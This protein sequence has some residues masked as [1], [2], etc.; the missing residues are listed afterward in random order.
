VVSGFVAALAGLLADDDRASDILGAIKDPASLDRIEEA[1]EGRSVLLE[2]RRVT[3][4]R[5]PEAPVSTPVVV[6]VEAE[7]RGAYMR[8]MFGPVIYVVATDSTK[9]SLALATESATR[10]GAIT[11]LV[12]STDTAVQELAEDAAVAAGVAVAFN[13]TGGLFVNQSAAFSD[14]HVT[15]ANPAGNASLTDPAFIAKRF[16]VVGVRKPV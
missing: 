16:R 8:E 15:G 2:S 1:A 10:H 4:S 12:Y 13:L 3:N 7:D 5:Y 11:W 14:F 6:A 9:E